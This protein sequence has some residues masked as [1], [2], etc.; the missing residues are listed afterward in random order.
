MKAIKIFLAGEFIGYYP[1]NKTGYN[2]FTLKGLTAKKPSYWD[3]SS[4]ER[5]KDYLKEEL[6]QAIGGATYEI[7]E[8]SQ[9]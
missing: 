3:N 8:K 1:S 6:S 7:V 4:I 2:P 5:F 9:L